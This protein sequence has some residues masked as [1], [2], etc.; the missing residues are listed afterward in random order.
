MPPRSRPKTT[1][2]MQRFSITQRKLIIVAFKHTTGIPNVSAQL[3]P[4]ASSL[5]I[6]LDDLN[7]FI[8][9][10][11]KVP[12]IPRD[13][14]PI[15]EL[16]SY[17]WI[18]CDLTI[19]W[20]LFLM[21]EVLSFSNTQPNQV[22]FQEV[23]TE[24]GYKDAL[25]AQSRFNA[26]MERAHADLGVNNSDSEHESDGKGALSSMSSQGKKAQTTPQSISKR[27]AGPEADAATTP[28]KRT[29]KP[30]GVKSEEKV[31][32]QSDKEEDKGKAEA[33]QSE[34]PPHVA[35]G[36]SQAVEKGPGKE[37]ECEDGQAGSTDAL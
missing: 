21:S 30:K 20:R 37:A 22:N 19:W 32:D 25:I 28:T 9:G 4:L 26:V 12:L 5:C 31:I 1:D 27:K 13:G 10:G 16:L 34:F 35:A 18:V 33:T 7:R 29:R 24:M 11:E 17:S 23:A 2:V 14:S 3:S 36:N 15:R 6:A 8:H